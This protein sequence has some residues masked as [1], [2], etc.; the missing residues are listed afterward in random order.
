[1]DSGQP[2]S[3]MFDHRIW[4]NL[5]IYLNVY[6]DVNLN[7]NLNVIKCKCKSKKGEMVCQNW[8]DRPTNFNYL[9]YNTKSSEI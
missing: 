6:L 2:K 8:V 9:I 7:L 1:M 3:N 4:L 5:N